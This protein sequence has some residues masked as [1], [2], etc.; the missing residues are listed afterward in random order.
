MLLMSVT[1]AVAAVRLARQNTLVQQMGATEAL[2]AVD[3]ICVDKTGTLTDGTLKLVA[4]EAADPARPGRRRAGAR[5]PSPPRPASATGPWRRSPSATRPTPSN[6]RAEVPFSSQWKWSGLTAERL[7]LRDRRP[8]RAHARRSPHPARRAC[9]G[10]SP[11]TPAPG[12]R[13]IAFGEARG[14]LPVRPGRRAAAAARAAGAG[15]A[16]GD[17]APRRR[18]DHRVHA[19]AA[20]RP[21]ADLRRRARDRDRGRARGRRARGRRR[22][23]GPATCPT[24]KGGLAQAAEHNTIFCRITPEQKKALVGALAERGRFT[25]MIGDGVNDVPALKQARLAV[26]MGSGSQ[27]TK[28]IADIVLLRDQ[29]SMLPRAVAEGRRIARNIHRLGRLYLTKSVYA[30]FLILLAAIF[31]FTFPFLPAPAHGGRAADDRH[32]V[33]RAR[34]GAERGPALPRPAVAGAG[35]VRVPGRDLDGDRLA[36]LVLYS[37]TASSAARS[38]RAGPPRPRR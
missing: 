10:R 14:G 26:A 24:D 36:A 7:Q 5:R 1:L 9:S 31:D 35:G 19:R 11:S 28:G 2:A 37:S 29:F 23:R 34:A 13:V 27:I 16:R 25:A 32:P 18:R 20:G 8:G 6:R 38:T 21:E 15:R 12:R 4:V 3:T 30:G 33:V 22:D 17:A